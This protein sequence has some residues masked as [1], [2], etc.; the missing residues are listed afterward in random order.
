MVE[1]VGKLMLFWVNSTAFA[2]EKDFNM[3]PSHNGRTIHPMIEI[4]VLPS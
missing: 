4:Q 3:N 2:E 1:L